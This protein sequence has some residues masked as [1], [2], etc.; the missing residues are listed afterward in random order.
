MGKALKEKGKKEVLKE[1]ETYEI[2]YFT[3]TQGFRLTDE[4]LND[5]AR[6]FIGCSRTKKGKKNFLIAY[7]F[8]GNISLACRRV[9][10]T[11]RSYMNWRKDPVFLEAVEEVK[12]NIKDWLKSH[13]LRHVA[14]GSEISNFFAL[15]VLAGLRESG[16][17]IDKSKKVRIGGNVTIITT[18]KKPTLPEFMNREEMSEQEREKELEEKTEYL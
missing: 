8:S 6:E 7:G 2:D 10:I 12:E 16:P 9:P 15:K 5:Y 1:L 14:E 17:V 4:Q 3:S 11:R 13:L 18:D